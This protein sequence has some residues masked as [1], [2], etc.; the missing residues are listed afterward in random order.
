V[1]YGLLPPGHRVNLHRLIAAIS[2]VVFA[3]IR[4]RTRADLA[5]VTRNLSTSRTRCLL[6]ATFTETGS[7]NLSDTRR[8]TFR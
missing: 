2:P 1:L 5:D 7:S 8:V 4:H 6:H 3:A